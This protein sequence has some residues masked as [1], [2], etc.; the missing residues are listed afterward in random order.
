MDKIIYF[1]TVDGTFL[2]RP[3]EEKTLVLKMITSYIRDVNT[4]Q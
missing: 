2:F 3:A 4:R 1:F